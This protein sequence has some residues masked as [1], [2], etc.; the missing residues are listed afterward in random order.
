MVCAGALCLKKQKQKKQQ[1]QQ[2][3]NPFHFNLKKNLF[4]RTSVIIV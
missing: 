3:T 4:Q 1:Q 2:L